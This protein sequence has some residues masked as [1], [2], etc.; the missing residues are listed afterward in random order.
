M[1]CGWGLVNTNENQRDG[2]AEGPLRTALCQALMVIRMNIHSDTA[3]WKL[4]AFYLQSQ[5]WHLCNRIKL[6]RAVYS[7]RQN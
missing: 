2:F 4:I 1:R 6:S 5:D 7:D 3:R